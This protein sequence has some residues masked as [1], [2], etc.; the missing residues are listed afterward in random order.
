MFQNLTFSARMSSSSF[1]F[2]ALFLFIAF[3]AGNCHPVGDNGTDS[4]FLNFT[5]LENDLCNGTCNSTAL[6]VTEWAAVSVLILLL[7]MLLL[8]IGMFFYAIC[9]S[10]WEAEGSTATN[11]CK[12]TG[13]EIVSTQAT[14]P[15]TQ[16]TQEKNENEH[17]DSE[18][19]FMKVNILRK[20]PE[21]MQD[22]KVPK[23]K[24]RS[25]VKW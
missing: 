17:R 8:T 23:G 15:S 13:K 9:H 16:K 20:A 4:F 11:L 25:T 6:T 12:A 10:F 18:N 1:R 2:F 7:I 22:E 21:G 14:P 19:D 3:T 5:S 24:V